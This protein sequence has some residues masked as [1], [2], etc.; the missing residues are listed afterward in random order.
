MDTNVPYMPSI[1]NLHDILDAIQKAAVPDGFG[2]DF[3]QDLG[4][5]S[6]YDRSSIKLLKFL[7]MLDSSGKPQSSYKEFINPTKAKKVLAERIKIAYDDLFVSDKN[8]QDKQ[9]NEL[10]GWFKTKTGASESVAKKMASTFKSLADYAD[11]QALENEKP[12]AAEKKKEEKKD[13]EPAGHT[14][15]SPAAF[16]KENDLGLVY[17]FEIHLPDT[18]N[19]E[20]YRAIFKAMREELGI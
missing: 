2:R 12:K 3:L 13:P 11:F 10:T 16:S 14:N 9:V 5:T 4:F 19:I 20:T 7:G 17:R 18:Q 6:S 15:G 8:A 1:K